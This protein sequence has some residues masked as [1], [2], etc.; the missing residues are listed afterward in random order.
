MTVKKT[1]HFALLR[2]RGRYFV[3]YIGKEKVIRRGRRISAGDAQYLRECSTR[4]DHGI[5]S[6]DGACV[7]DLGLAVFHGGAR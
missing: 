4:N 5:S 3:R 2:T 6:F 7:L 1:R